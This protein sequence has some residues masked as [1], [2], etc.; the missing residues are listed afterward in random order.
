MNRCRIALNVDGE[1]TVRQ[2]VPAW[3]GLEHLPIFHE[4][5]MDFL[6]Y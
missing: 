3:L 5:L 6:K 2:F 1:R 4:G